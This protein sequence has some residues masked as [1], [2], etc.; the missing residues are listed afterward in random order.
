MDWANAFAGALGAGLMG[1]TMGGVGIKEISATQ[2]KGDSKPG[3]FATG[4]GLTSGVAGAIDASMN[5]KLMQ[6][7]IDLTKDMHYK[8]LAQI[9]AR[10]D[11]LTK[12]TNLD[13]DSHLVPYIEIYSASD[14]EI[15]YLKNLLK[16]RGYTINRINTFSE[17]YFNA[18]VDGA[19]SVFISGRLIECTDL[20]EDAHTFS[21][22]N[23]ELMTGVRVTI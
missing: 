16:Y 1:Y 18:F 15:N 21:E 9:K 13:I 2:S 20:N 23:N 14:D 5:Q 8:N 7:N 12:V 6:E 19:E 3:L 11:T 4:F 17:Q 10:P 22:L